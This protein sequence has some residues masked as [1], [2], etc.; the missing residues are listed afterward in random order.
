MQQAAQCRHGSGGAVGTGGDVEGCSGGGIGEG[1]S[2][3]V[4]ANGGFSW[5][6]EGS[7]EGVPEGVGFC[8]VIDGGSRDGIVERAVGVDESERDCVSLG[9]GGLAATKEIR[10]VRANMRIRG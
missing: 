4:I 8:S 2:G 7:V 10:L 1:F 9:V 5:A 6:M 3:G